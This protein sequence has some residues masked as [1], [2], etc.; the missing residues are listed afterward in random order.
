MGVMDRAPAP[1]MIGSTVTSEPRCCRFPALAT[2]RRGAHT[3]LLDQSAL[4]GVLAEIEALTPDR[5]SPDQVTAA[6]RDSVPAI[7]LGLSP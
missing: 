2:Q 6:H 1:Y 5:K 4:Y 3:V 7:S